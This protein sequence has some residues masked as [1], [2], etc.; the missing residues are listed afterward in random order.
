MTVA[1]QK[2]SN[3][4]S[5]LLASS[6]S[7]TDLAIQVAAGFGALFP[8]PGAQEYF[9]V[10]LVNAA[11]DR[12]VVKI[13][14][15][16]TDILTVPPGGRGQEGTSA[17]SWTGGLTRVECRMTAGSLALF[18]QRGGDTMEGD[19]DMDDNELQNAT[20]IEPSIQ[21]GESV[22]TPMRGVSGDASN[23]LAVPDDGTR[24]TAG[25]ERIVVESDVELIKETV[26][27]VGMIMDW[28]GDAAD[29]PGGWHICNGAGGTPD[30]RGLFVRGATLDADIAAA[31]GGSATASG[32]TGAAG[33]L[34]EGVSGSHVLTVPEIPAHTHP[35]SAHVFIDEADNGTP[36]RYIVDGGGPI[37]TGSTGGDGG[38]T[39]V[40]PAVDNHTHSLSAVPIIPPF[41]YLYKIMFI[42]F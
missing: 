34:A 19:L 4:A 12:E 22:G 41:K 6:I 21:G 11:G 40:L 23:E 8:N 18:I 25:G 35:I 7:D 20:I 5:S 38:H 27:A 17:S 39:H 9:V 10:T 15:R 2:F 29:C 37:N 32:D 26:F 14:S 36:I 16:T 3:G 31:A 33:G 28:F 24:A 42:G 13:T 30:L 1:K